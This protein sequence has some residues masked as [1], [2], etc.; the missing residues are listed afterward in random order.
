[1]SP[2][3]QVP[4][5]PSSISDISPFRR[6][7]AAEVPLAAQVRGQ[8]P[9][10]LRGKLVRT[11]PAVF[12]ASRWRAEHWFDGLGMLYAF[13]IGESAV[14]FRSRLLDCETARN[15]AAG[16]SRHATFGTPMVRSLWQRIFEPVPRPTDNTNVNIV[17]LG[18]ELVAM[19]E[20]DRQLSIDP[21]TLAV[22]SYVAYERDELDGAI[23]SAHPHFDFQRRRVV[24]LATKL[25]AQGVVSVYEH[26]PTARRRTLVGSWRTP[27]L[28]Y[29]HSFGLT[30]ENAVLIAHPFSV[31]PARLLWSNRGFIDHFA[32]QPEQGTRLIVM[33]RATGK[34]REH[35]TDPM[36]VFHT[37]NAF[38]R[39]GA[40][41]LDVLAYSSAD[42]VSALRVDRLSEALPD[43][44]PSLTRITLE[45][46]R[47]RASVELLSDVGFEF[48]ATHYQRVNGGEYRYAWGAS[49]AAVD[50][51]Y[52]SAIVKVDVRSGASSS[53]GDGVH[54]FGEPVFVARPGGQ[55]EDDGV[56][57]SVGSRKDA[58]S[59]MLA[60]LDAKTL[61]LLASAEVPSAIP[62]GFHGSF[63]R[64]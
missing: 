63:F 9:A 15:A 47:E 51:G 33:D 6:S 1:M 23:M 12:E 50:S 57:V 30:P 3:I 53:F 28:P 37:V 60:V 58:D 46:G 52:A 61:S 31:N 8:I 25:G 10:W 45:H 13:E 19:T 26:A 22:R 49:E 5:A 18:D 11:C 42:I 48:P 32:W 59:T 17:K 2:A 40:T 55:E 54:V 39:D 35:V 29:V 21:V 14:A 20:G 41:V 38:E 24:N 36:F 4:Q 43:L 34:T 27:R 7:P 44:R 16:K 62:L 64:A 56:L